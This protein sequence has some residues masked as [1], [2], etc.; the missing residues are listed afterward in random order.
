MS[1]P[2]RKLESWLEER[3]LTDAVLAEYIRFLYAEGK[4]RGNNQSRSIAAVKWMAAHKGADYAG[5]TNQ[6][7]HAF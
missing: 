6:H 4:S 2:T 1:T 5:G 7:S 3:R